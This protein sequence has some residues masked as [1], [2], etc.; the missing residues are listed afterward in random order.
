MLC[1]ATVLFQVA[2]AAAVWRALPAWVEAPWPGVAAAAVVLLLGGLAWRAAHRAPVALALLEHGV[3]LWHA[4][5]VV[6]PALML[7]A[8]SQCGGLLLNLTLADT[9]GRSTCVLIAA[10][11]VDPADFRLLAV[12]A[13]IRC[14]GR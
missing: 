8:F 5:G 9:D 2:C 14:T 11:A 1:A 6:K 10:D 4:G 12:H 3:T 13:R 7:R